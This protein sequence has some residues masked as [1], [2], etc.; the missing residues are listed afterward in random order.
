M[1]NFNKIYQILGCMVVILSLTMCT[2]KKK[3]IEFPVNVGE[4]I[5]CIVKGFNGNYYVTVMNGKE[6]GDAEIRELSA[7]GVKT[8]SKGFDEPKG[9]AFVQNNLYF[10]DLWR[11]WKVD[12]EGNAEIFADSAD[13]PHKPLYLNDVSSNADGTG[14]YVVDMGRSDIMRDENGNLWPLDSDE[15]AAIPRLGRVYHI[16]LDGDVTVAQDTSDLMINPNGVGIDNNGNFMIGAFFTGNFLVNR[17]GALTPLKG[18]FRGADA[19]EQ[20]SKGNYYI[21]SWQQGKVWKI[22]GETEES[23]I[24]IE[25]LKTAAD[26]YLE[27][28]KGRLLLPDM[29]T[30]L[31]HSVPIN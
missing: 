23:T 7:D 9:M 14:I 1:K 20:D 6:S 10:S 8:F 29:L 13:F 4:R 5:E 12:A 26:F 3:E 17:G 16:T 19:V 15:A 30:G 21:S 31:V 28:D 22:D 18:Q 24:L 25:G 11:V 27:E 2:P